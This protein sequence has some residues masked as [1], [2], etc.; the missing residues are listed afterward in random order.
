VE[1]KYGNIIPV[2]GDIL[3]QRIDH[4]GIDTTPPEVIAKQIIINFKEGAL[5]QF[6]SVIVNQVNDL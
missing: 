3:N 2:T 1:Q 5:V 6:Q 4:Q